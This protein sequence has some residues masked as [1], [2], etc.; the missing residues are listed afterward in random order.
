VGKKGRGDMQNLMAT[1]VKLKKEFRAE[2]IS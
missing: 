2:E 1:N